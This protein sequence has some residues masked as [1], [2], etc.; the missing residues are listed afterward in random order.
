MLDEKKWKDRLYRAWRYSATPTESLWELFKPLLE[1]NQ[2]RQSAIAHYNQFGEMPTEE[3]CGFDDIPPK[4]SGDISERLADSI[5]PC[6][7]SFF[8]NGVECTK[9]EFEAIRGEPLEAMFPP[10]QSEVMPTSGDALSYWW[11]PTTG[12]VYR[13]APEEPPKQ[14]E[15]IQTSPL[16]EHSPEQCIQ[17]KQSDNISAEEMTAIA[18]FGYGSSVHL[19]AKHEREKAHDYTIIAQLA[20]T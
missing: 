14:S 16:C 4:Q 15:K 7:A 13:H 5:R 8:H 6:N 2:H 18:T 19:R 12:D 3:I 1:Q 9:E 10:K 17:T 20:K 11:S